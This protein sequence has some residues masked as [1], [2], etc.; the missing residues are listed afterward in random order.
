MLIMIMIMT[1]NTN[2]DDEGDIKRPGSSGRPDEDGG[3]DD[4][5]II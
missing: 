5:M 1:L 3:F 4:H 2:H